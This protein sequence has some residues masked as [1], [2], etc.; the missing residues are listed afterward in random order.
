MFP[1]GYFS[2]AYFNGFFPGGEGDGG[3][4]GVAPSSSSDASA[5]GYG[6]QWT[7]RNPQDSDYIITDDD[8]EAII[9]DRLVE[10][11]ATSLR[12][13]VHATFLNVV[14]TKKG[15]TIFLTAVFSAPPDEVHVVYTQPQDETPITDP[16]FGQ[17][18]TQIRC[19]D[20]AGVTYEFAIVTRDFEVGKLAWHMWGVFPSHEEHDDGEE[21][22][23]GRKPQLL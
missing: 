2:D 14:V 13:A 21:T 20:E 10:V 1:E 6:D 8:V 5:F 12:V 16:G 18:G 9:R 23:L 22:I 7:D 4:V 11:T 15:N 3:S 17:R 19:L